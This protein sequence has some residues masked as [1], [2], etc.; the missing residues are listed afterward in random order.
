MLPCC[1]PPSQAVAAAGNSGLSQ[2]LVP[3]LERALVSC[4]SA[5]DLPAENHSGNSLLVL[6]GCGS[7]CPCRGSSACASCDGTAEWLLPVAQGRRLHRVVGFNSVVALSCSTSAD[8]CMR[9]NVD[10]CRCCSTRGPKALVIKG[11]LENS[12]LQK[13][14]VLCQASVAAELQWPLRTKE[15]AHALRKWPRLPL[16]LG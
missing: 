3:G 5:C 13:K 7:L 15:D 12:L 2:Q 9:E 8:C 4:S 14:P 16:Y 11:L 1:G 6:H 10:V